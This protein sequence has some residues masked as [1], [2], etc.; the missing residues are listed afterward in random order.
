MKKIKMLSLLLVL[1]MLL[2]LMAGCGGTDDT[3]ANSSPSSNASAGS[4][5]A[6]APSSTNPGTGAPAGGQT[7]TIANLDEINDFD[8]FTNQQ[9]TYLCLINNN[10]METLLYIDADMEYAPGLATSWT[11]SDDGLSY[12]F[13]LREG[14]KF[15]DGA[16][17]TAED[18]KYTI[19]Y[20]VD[21]DNGCWRA[22]YFSSIAGIECPDDHTVRLTLS[23]PAPALLDS[24]SSLA[25]VSSQQ[26]PGTYSSTLNGTG[27][28][29]FVS[30]TANDA[31]VFEKD[32]DYWD[33]AN[34][35]LDGLTIKFVADYTTAIT[36]LK[37]G[38][39][40]LIYNL[41]ASY[42]EDVEAAD[43]LKVVTSPTSNSTYLF[44]IGLHNVPAFQEENVL[45]AMFMC[46]DTQTM[47]DEVFYGYASPS[48]GVVHAGAKYY[49]DV[50]DGTYDIEAAKALL[51]TTS[52][53]D[54]FDF[55]MYCMAGPFE[56]IAV[57]W[58]QALAQI[59]IS[60]KI[61]VQEMSV[62]LEHYL[63]RDYDMISNSYSMVGTDPAT[64]MTLV[65]GGLFDYQASEALVPGLQDLIAQGASTASDSER[66]RI[67]GDIFEILAEKMPLYTYLSVDN[68]YAAKANLEGISFNGEARY[69]FT[70]A[71]F[72]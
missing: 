27:P 11:V 53:A 66:E 15:H 56:G 70:H 65:V 40:D 16:D 42:A 8:P 31:V 26:D 25:I 57:I 24:F 22:G 38:D 64:M 39:I 29:R 58:Q 44:E 43:G 61:E 60:M 17:F 7:V 14:V 50:Y 63:S 6:E 1:A 18:V 3:P 72:S 49:Q 20:T 52:Y 2:G 19:E 13:Q 30:Y 4:G 12:E 68:L 33:A 35:Q 71:Y 10:C 46:L 51:A 45:K 21:P 23:A 37:A 28:F 54:G 47:A 48:L 69:I 32:A 34:V 55:T 5:D 36:S 62:W 59:G 9:T 41:D 67:Y